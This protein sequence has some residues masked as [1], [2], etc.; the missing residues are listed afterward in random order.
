MPD[1]SRKSGTAGGVCP[2]VQDSQYHLNV[3][4]QQNYTSKK[5]L[6]QLRISKYKYFVNTRQNYR[7][8]AIFLYVVANGHPDKFFRK[9]VIPL[10]QFIFRNICAYKNFYLFFFIIKSKY[11]NIIQKFDNMM[12]TQQLSVRIFVNSDKTSHLS[13]WSCSIKNCLLHEIIMLQS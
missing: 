7:K 12:I 3:L 1:R 13:G 8:Q 11:D 10:Y 2:S 5:R 4:I 9:A 6:I